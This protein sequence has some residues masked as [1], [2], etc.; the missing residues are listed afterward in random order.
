VP[1][2]AGGLSAVDLRIA[3][4]SHIRAVG[5][6]YRGRLLAWDVVNEAVA[7]GGSGLRD[8]V[9]RQKLGDGYIAEAFRLAHEADPQALLFLQRL[10]R[11]GPGREVESG[12]SSSV[13][14]L[15]AQGVP[16]DGVGLQMHVSAAGRPA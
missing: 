11:R 2:W 7:D 1:A 16:I 12:S 10:R 13:S 5:E 15:K 14:E 8:T 3:V 6:H 9:F 4:E